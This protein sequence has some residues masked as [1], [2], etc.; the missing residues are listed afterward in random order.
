MSD[1]PNL[2]RARERRHSLREAMTG[3]E[4]R[5]ST[6]TAADGWHQAVDAAID[7]LRYALDE[8]I[9][10]VEGR[11]GLLEEILERAPRLSRQTQLIE[12]EHERL[13]DAC[14]RA[15]EAVR[16]SMNLV[17]PDPEQVRRC[18][19][20]LLGRLTLHRQHGADLVYEAYN[21]DISAGD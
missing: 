5:V 6:P 4:T 3:L 13:T 1:T 7:E 17:S 15:K 19:V 9:E 8:H 21:V 12:A 20:S 11:G 18:V 16:G 10:G 14:E 2:A